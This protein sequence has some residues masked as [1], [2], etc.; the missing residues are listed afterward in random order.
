MIRVIQMMGP[1]PNQTKD[2]DVIVRLHEAVDRFGIPKWV[3]SDSGLTS[4]INDLNTS[5]II[6]EGIE[7]TA[8]SP[9]PQKKACPSDQIT[10]QSHAAPP[11][12]L[13]SP[14]LSPAGQVLW[15]PNPPTEAQAPFQPDLSLMTLLALPDLLTHYISLPPGLQSHYI[16]T[17][18]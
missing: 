6:M 18:L 11:S 8:Y 14:Q 17:L 7:D 10:S 1:S 5:D 4:P 13:P 16:L 3:H 9:P 12:P 15:A 2:K